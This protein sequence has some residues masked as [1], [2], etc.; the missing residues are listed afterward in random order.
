MHHA[1]LL[2]D[3]N[4]KFTTITVMNMEQFLCFLIKSLLRNETPVTVVSCERTA[5]NLMKD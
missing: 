5:F 3:S 2:T 4:M 1:L